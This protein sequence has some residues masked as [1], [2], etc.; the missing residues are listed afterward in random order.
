MGSDDNVDVQKRSQIPGAV[1]FPSAGNQL[2]HAK[3]D[4]PFVG[5]CLFSP[6]SRNS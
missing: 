6:L 3:S 2:T 1:V 4:R 5:K